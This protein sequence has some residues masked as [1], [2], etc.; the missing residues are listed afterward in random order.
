LGL[1]ADSLRHWDAARAT[2]TNAM[3]AQIKFLITSRFQRLVAT[4][5]VVATA[6][7]ALAWTGGVRAQSRENELYLIDPVL[8]EYHPNH[9]SALLLF[10]NRVWASQSLDSAV[11]GL[12]CET[13]VVAEVEVLR[14]TNC[15]CSYI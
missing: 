11:T 3:A 6:V 14:P 15:Q 9:E 5:A 2:T 7:S 10:I 12:G 13:E 1:S 4:M 8:A